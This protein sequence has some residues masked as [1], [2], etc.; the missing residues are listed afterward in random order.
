MCGPHFCSMKI[1]QDVREYAETHGVA[2]D[3][4]LDAGM[5][6]KSAEFRAAGAQLYRP[7]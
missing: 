2:A 3:E 4:A 7:D 6:E 5:A 1:T